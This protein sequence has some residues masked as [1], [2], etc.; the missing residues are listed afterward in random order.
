MFPGK[1]KPGIRLSVSSAQVRKKVPSAK[2]RSAKIPILHLSAVAFL[3][4]QGFVCGR[5][6]MYEDRQNS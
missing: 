6:L 4:Y 3:K 5:C 1:R 2:G